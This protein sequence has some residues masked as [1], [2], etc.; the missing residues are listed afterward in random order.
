[1]GTF[2]HS[3]PSLWSR[4]VGVGQVVIRAASSSVVP[5]LPLIIL[6]C[7]ADELPS[8]P[9]VV[10]HPVQ[11]LS[12]MRRTD[13][14]SRKCNRPA[15]VVR[16][17]QV[18]R[19]KVEPRLS[20]LACNLLAKEPVRSTLADEPVEG[21]PQVPLVVKPFSLACR[22]ER[23][24]WTGAGPDRP[25]IGPAC[26]SECVAPDADPGEEVALSKSSKV[27]WRD[28]LDIP[29]VNM[30]GR[31]VSGVDQFAEPLG[32]KRIDLV[33]VGYCGDG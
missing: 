17:F 11:T 3:W 24:A 10:G 29:F 33:V 14:A 1:M 15:G 19:Y 12:L 20:S 28:I 21:G 9:V 13:A 16:C 18:S 27:R 4:V 25:V 2:G 32:S 7:R 5:G 30:S 23:L 22:A 8:L 6:P 26:L 31:D